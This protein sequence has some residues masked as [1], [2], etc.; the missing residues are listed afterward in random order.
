MKKKNSKISNN[1]SYIIKNPKKHKN[2]NKDNSNRNQTSTTFTDNK[3]KN[4]IEKYSNNISNRDN[5]C[6]FN[7][8]IYK[9]VLSPNIKNIKH[10][11]DYRTIKLENK[12]FF[13]EKNM[14][15]YYNT[16]TFSQTNRG[17]KIFKKLNT[18]QNEYNN[19][20]NNNNIFN[21]I[22]NLN[23]NKNKE[24]ELCKD[25]ISKNSIYCLDCMV[26]SCPY[27]PI[28]NLHLD[29]NYI[30]TYNFYFNIKQIFDECFNDIDCLFSLNP[31]YLDINKMKGEI[32]IQI[33]NQI[34]QIIEKLNTIKNN[35]IKEIDKIICSDENNVELLKIKKNII[36]NN[37]ISF[38]NKKEYFLNFKN[39]KN[40]N[41][42]NN[43][44]YN[45]SFLLRY[46]LLKDIEIINNKIKSIILDIKANSQK[47]LDD[48]NKKVLNITNNLDGLN[49]DF[50]GEFKYKDLKVDLYKPIDEKLLIYNEKINLIKKNIF[51]KINKKGGYENIEKEIKI[52]KQRLDKGNINL[53][54]SEII[55]KNKLNNF[56][57][58]YIKKDIKR[59]KTPEK[60]KNKNDSNNDKERNIYQNKNNFQ[61][62]KSLEDICL[63]NKI[64]H[65]FYSLGIIN[66]ISSNNIYKC[67]NIIKIQ[68]KNENVNTNIIEKDNIENYNK[69]IPIPETNEIHIFNK[70]TGKI[71]KKNVAFNISTHKYSYFLN[72]SRY[73][74]LND[75]LYIFGGVTKEKIESKISYIYSV[76]KNELT[77]LPEM[78]KPHSY[79]S[80]CYIEKYNSI[81]V[82]G[83]ENNNSC[84][85]YNIN[86]NSWT[87]LSDMNYT[88]AN[89]NLYYDKNKDYLYTFFGISGKISENKKY[90]DIIEYLDLKQIPLVWKKIKYNNKTNMDLKAEYLKINP[91]SDDIILVNGGKKGKAIYLINKKEFVKFDRKILNQISNN[92]EE[93][94]KMLLS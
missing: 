8:E 19:D 68:K 41:N 45:V 80:I 23:E 55:E 30:Y 71:I 4:K 77:P 6:K 9:N 42:C 37:I 60:T 90:L 62:F 70:K 91:I 84:E 12:N 93:I 50:D 25:D 38:F 47:Y 3:N 43:D 24:N 69:I 44:F 79:H 83:G 64:L 22:D 46:K 13:N 61:I 74:L 32:K 1:N 17:H 54:D 73:I 26:S 76:N 88:K 27:C 87:N 11:I 78:L 49:E 82:I 40:E 21:L 16:I 33:N 31:F 85:L 57:T 34:N 48:F 2:I 81:A 51:D 75:L 10:I 53:L 67:N 92:K 14:Q 72:G 66:I 56:K 35:K 89:C 20:K 7:K 63:N 65:T 59:Q 28:Y 5:K 58:F 15:Q 86:S 39:N 52:L 29:H 18:D 36:K 94:M